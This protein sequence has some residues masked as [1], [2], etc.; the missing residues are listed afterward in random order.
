MGVIFQERLGS[1]YS[2]NGA[3]GSADYDL[4]LRRH[5]GWY[6]GP[7]VVSCNAVAWEG[8]ISLKASYDGTT[9]FRPS[10]TCIRSGTTGQFPN[11]YGGVAA[12]PLTNT[13]TAFVLNPRGPLDTLRV[14]I[15]AKAGSV[16]VTWAAL[17]M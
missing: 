13:G 17:A 1:V 9:F 3:T 16:D 6:A 7:L 14:S 4:Q 8:S 11:Q 12:G 15:Q 10:V 2:G 5:G